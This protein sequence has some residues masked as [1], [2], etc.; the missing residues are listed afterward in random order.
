MSTDATAQAERIRRGEITPV[1]LLEETIQRIEKLN[2][3]LN[4]IIM[5]LYEKARGEA[6]SVPDGPFRGVPYVLKDLSLVSKGDPYVAGIAGVKAAG[7]RSDHDSYFVERMRAAG[8][9]L[10]G[11]A[12][13]PELGIMGPTEPRT[14]GWTRNP[15]NTVYQTG[16]GGGAATAVA[17]GM[18]ALAHGN[19][20]GG[21]VRITAGQCGVVGLMPSR[22]R[23]SPGPDIRHS[24]NV[25]GM[26]REGLIARSVRDVAATLDIVSGHR[27]GDGYCAPNPLRPFAAEVG[28]DPGR[29]RIG[30][31]DCDPAGA[32]QIDHNCSRAV[33]ATAKVL[34]RLGHEVAPGF[35]SILRQGGWPEAFNP[36]IAVVV[37]R[38][39]ASFGKLIGRPLTQDDVEPVTWGYAEMGRHV[40]ADMYA[41]G[42]DSLRQRAIE[43]ERWWDEGWDLLMT[44]TMP[45]RSLRVDETPEADDSFLQLAVAITLFAVPYNVSGQP[46]ISLPL[47][48]GDDGMPV[49]VQM[50]AAYGREDLLLRIGAQLEQAMPWAHRY[51]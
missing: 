13:S 21:S 40:T 39:L 42:V 22:G 25:A 51:R 20:G 50:V 5:P 11:R 18:V 8:F 34:T 15:W 6:Q 29:L 31:L 45:V 46:A 48:W 7:Y 30:I 32:I 26:L 35:P 44:P 3:T 41:A 28:R 10:V 33:R 12:N 16:G 27:P 2:P 38:E 36:C 23:V 43:T 1:E 14:W 47:Y 19:D 9:V 49:G 17:S 37:A 4:A 24:D